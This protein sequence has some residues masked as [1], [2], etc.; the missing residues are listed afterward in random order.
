VRLV[1]RRGKDGDR[2]SRKREA[3]GDVNVELSGEIG[4]DLFTSAV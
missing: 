3:A 1:K 2:V 4:H